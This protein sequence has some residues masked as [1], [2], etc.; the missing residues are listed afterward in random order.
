M[1]KF[2]AALAVL[3]LLAAPVKAGVLGSVL[4]MDGVPDILTDDSRAFKTGGPAIAVGDELFGWIQITSTT[5]VGAI[6]PPALVGI[7][8]AKITG[9][10]GTFLSPWTLGVNTG[11]NTLASL[12]P[13]LTAGATAGELAKSIFVLGGL[14]A[15][16]NAGALSGGA[17][18]VGAK[19]ELTAIDSAMGFEALIGLDGIDDYFNAV[20]A[21]I[22]VEDG[23]FSL[24]K[25]S[26]GAGTTLLPLLGTGGGTHDILL[27]GLVFPTPDAPWHFQDN[28][29][30]T[31]NAVPEPTSFAVWG[32]I[33]GIGGMSRLRR[34][35]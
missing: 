21:G 31:V 6:N 22:I 34:K 11:V 8:S 16:F 15:A 33:V 19:A 10:A 28:V 29:N 4:T 20:F 35:K 32:L 18:I 26:L 12:A 27:N 25:S 9:G 24:I 1:K 2:L 3:V 5:A 13:T 14:P 30:F 7:Y 23:G 17:G